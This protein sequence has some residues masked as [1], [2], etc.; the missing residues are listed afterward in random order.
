MAQLGAMYVVSSSSSSSISYEK[1]RKKNTQ[2]PKPLEWERLL[3]IHP[4]GQGTTS[5]S[6]NYQRVNK[7]G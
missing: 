4:L 1:M 6:R 7:R 3:P 5:A 2:G